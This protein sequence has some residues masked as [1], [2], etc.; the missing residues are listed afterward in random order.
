MA[1]NPRV[2]MV[3]AWS[4]F[5]IVWIVSSFM[6]KRIAK[7]EGGAGIAARAL[8]IAVAW[9][10]IVSADDPRLGILAADFLPQSLRIAWLG[11]AMTFAGVLFAVWAR[12][13]IGRYWSAT[14]ALKDEHELIRSGPYARIRHPIY[15]G[16]IFAIAGSAVVVGTYGA[17]LA[18]AVIGVSFWFKGRQEEALLASQFGKAFDEHRHHTGFFLPPLS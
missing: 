10:L 1:I 15:T 7:R 13:H 18:W 3:A 9:I 16:M 12:V 4:V 17:L 2:A 6:A 5:A 11:A 8:I 14:V